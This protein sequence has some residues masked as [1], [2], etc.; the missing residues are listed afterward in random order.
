MKPLCQFPG[1]V[2]TYLTFAEQNLA[3]GALVS[4][5]LLGKL[6]LADVMLLHQL[7]KTDMSWGFL[8]R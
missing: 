4:D 1:K 3:E 5:T 7:L 2:F 8:K 6:V